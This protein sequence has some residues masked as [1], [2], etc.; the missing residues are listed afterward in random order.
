MEDG[1]K[2]LGHIFGSSEDTVTTTLA[3]QSGAS[4][5]QIS[6]M[7]K[8]LAPLVLSAVNKEQSSGGLT[9]IVGSLTQSTKAANDNSSLPMQVVTSLLDKDGDGSIVDD[10]TD[11][12]TSQ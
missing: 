3:T 9:D 1:S 12:A 11:I 6:S 10:L 8:I 2:I 4:T 5:D 7:M